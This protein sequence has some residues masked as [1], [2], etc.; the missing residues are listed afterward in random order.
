[1]AISG[2]DANGN[3]NI[4]KISREESLQESTKVSRAEQ[5]LPAGQSSDDSDIS[6]KQ[7]NTAPR[8]S[9]PNDFTFDFKKNNDFNLVAARNEM[10]DIDLEKAMSDMQKETVLNQYKYFV[11]TPNLGRDDDGMVRIVKR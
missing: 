3:Y 2:I 4:S 10:E 6:K 11:G 5:I 1:M 8:Q 9:D 7:V